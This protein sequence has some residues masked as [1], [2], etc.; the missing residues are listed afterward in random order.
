[1]V[2]HPVELRGHRSRGSSSRT[3]RHVGFVG[4]QGIHTAVLFVYNTDICY[5]L[6]YST[7]I[8]FLVEGALYYSVREGHK[9]P[10]A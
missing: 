5:L 9:I 1:M 4:I 10:R 3:A 6:S 8:I 7:S 2:E